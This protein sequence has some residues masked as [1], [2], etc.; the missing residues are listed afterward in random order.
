LLLPLRHDPQADTRHIATSLAGEL[1][2]PTEVAPAASPDGRGDEP[3][4]T[5][6]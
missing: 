3:G 4:A 6:T 2:F 5:L 1:G